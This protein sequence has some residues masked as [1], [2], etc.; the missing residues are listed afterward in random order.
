MN[1]QQQ[2]KK[3]LSMKFTNGIEKEIRLDGQQDYTISSSKHPNADLHLHDE[4]LDGMNLKIT[5]KN[6][7][8]Y[9]IGD[10][11]NFVDCY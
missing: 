8:F 10:N 2:T 1:S 6:G 3:M 9:F 11:K 5:Y 7:S 4:S